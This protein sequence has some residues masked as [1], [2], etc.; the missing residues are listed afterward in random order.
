MQAESLGA[1]EGAGNVSAGLSRPGSVCATCTTHNAWILQ[2]LL[3]PLP[4]GP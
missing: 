3:L 2:I 1:G 4:A